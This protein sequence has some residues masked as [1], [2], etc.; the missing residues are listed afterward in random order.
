M[1]IIVELIH[2]LKIMIVLAAQR[3]LKDWIEN[4]EKIYDDKYKEIEKQFK[5]RLEKLTRIADENHKELQN[6]II[7][8]KNN[9]ISNLKK[10]NEFLSQ[11]VLELEHDLTDMKSESGIGDE[12][13]E[14]EEEIGIGRMGDDGVENEGEVGDSEEGVGDSF[15][16]GSITK[17][18]IANYA[19][20]DVYRLCV[21]DDIY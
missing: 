13:E 20:M 4:I 6:E 18:L 8:L 10:D 19:K 2:V 11:R 14:R 3:A 5:Y 7:D 15:I 16:D 1:K 12:K 21:I 9:V 17:K